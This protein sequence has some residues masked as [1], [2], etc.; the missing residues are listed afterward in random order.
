M[1]RTSVSTL[2]RILCVCLLLV[3]GVCS[4][5]TGATLSPARQ[6]LETATNRILDCIKNPDYVNPATR[7]PIRSRIEDEVLHVF[8]FSEFS[9]RTVGP[10]W[11]AFTA[12]QQ[13]RFSDVFADLLISTYV[14]KIDGYNGEQVIYTGELAS[15]EGDR[16]EVRTL[17][18]M[19]D[20][21]KIPVAY[22]M[23]P[24]GGTWLVYDV[25]VEN[26]SLVKN[27]RTQFQDILTNASPDQLIERVQAKALEVRR[28]VK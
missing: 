1:P 23:L 8:D 22:R 2:Q 14:N 27:Y 6:T 12:D 24:K 18:T 26:I 5:A 9:S 17:I 11:R 21:K 10:R 3:L 28:N 7:A 19:K 15:P 13:K 25:L 20:G 16:V 4:Q